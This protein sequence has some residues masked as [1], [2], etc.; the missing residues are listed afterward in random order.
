MR[1]SVIAVILFSGCATPRLGYYYPSIDLAI[2]RGTRNQLNEQCTN[3]TW[4]NGEIRKH[5]ENVLACWKPSTR[6]IWVQDTCDGARAIPH[7]MAHALEN[8][9]DPDSEGY[10]W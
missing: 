1:Y 5:N 3:R 6:E 9:K 8:I 10:D 2:I 7:E 4:D